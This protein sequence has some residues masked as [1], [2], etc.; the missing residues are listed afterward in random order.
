MSGIN[1]FVDWLKYLRLICF[2]ILHEHVKKTRAKIL[3]QFCVN[4]EDSICLIHIIRATGFRVF[5]FVF[6][7]LFL[8]L[9]FRAAS[10]AYGWSQAR[11]RIGVAAAGPH[12]SHSN[13]GSLT[14]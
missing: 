8:F 10:M 5:K 13:A 3:N 11:S 7:F 12:H 9:L 4:L 14:Y 6:V 2:L 1:K